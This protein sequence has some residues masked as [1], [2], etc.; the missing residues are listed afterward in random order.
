MRVSRISL[1]SRGSTPGRTEG[2]A[3]ATPLGVMMRFSGARPPRSVP[4]GSSWEEWVLTILGGGM[5]SG[6]L[7][8]PTRPKHSGAAAVA[9]VVKEAERSDAGAKVPAQRAPDPSLGSKKSFN[10][11]MPAEGD[12]TS[13]NGTGTAPRPR[14]PPPGRGACAH[15]PAAQTR[16]KL[17]AA[18]RRRRRRRQPREAGGPGMSRSRGCMR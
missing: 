2:G 9:V 7:A 5:L 10:P 6:G 1:S 15:P 18:A 11:S 17:P 16:R 14:A 4:A 3:K 12:S 8:G 13:T